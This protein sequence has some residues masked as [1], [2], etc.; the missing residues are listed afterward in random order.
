MSSGDTEGRVF[1]ATVGICGPG[2]IGPSLPSPEWNPARRTRSWASGPRS[3]SAKS[4][5]ASAAVGS[6]AVTTYG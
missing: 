3:Q 5:E 2:E 1:G 6:V 4:V